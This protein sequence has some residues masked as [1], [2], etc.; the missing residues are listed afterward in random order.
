VDLSA[1]RWRALAFEGGWSWPAV[2]RQQERR[3]YLV[4]AGGVRW[5]AEFVGIGGA[6]ERRHARARAL[7]GAGFAPSPAGL[8]HGFLVRPWVDATP[9][10]VA[11]SDPELLVRRVAEYLAFRARSFGAARGEGAS[12]GE[13]LAMARHNARVA[14]GEAHAAEVERFAD[15]AQLAAR[16]A[17]PAAVDG[18]LEPW[19]WLLARDGRLLKVDALQHADAHDL[20]GCQDVGWDVA[21]ARFELAL[22]CAEHAEL[23]RRVAC[24]SGAELPPAALAFYEVAYLALRV[25]RWHWAAT[26]EGDVA[27]RVRAEAELARYRAALAARLEGR[28]AGRPAG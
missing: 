14:L 1:G 13:L 25:A 5:L 4:V 17:R 3:K 6:G 21:A 20:A 19:E 7:G 9:L 16:D 24:M 15:G 22:G 10:A 12:P 2:F 11:E 8:C 26:T 18:K 28:A 23:A 27:E